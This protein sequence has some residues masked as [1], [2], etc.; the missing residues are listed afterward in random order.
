MKLHQKKKTSFWF[1]QG[2]ELL[3]FLLMTIWC[4]FFSMKYHAQKKK[5]TLARL[6]TFPP[7]QEVL[8]QVKAKA[9]YL[10]NTEADLVLDYAVYSKALE[11]NMDPRNQE[12]QYFINLWMNSFHTSC[13]FITVIGKRNWFE[14]SMY[15]RNAKWDRI[16]W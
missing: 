7:V 16:S 6:F 3:S 5:A 12:L 10:R 1:V 8:H 4:L 11:V 15:R 14:R 13:I 9:G 2:K